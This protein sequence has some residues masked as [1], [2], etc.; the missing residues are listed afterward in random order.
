MET[1]RHDRLTRT[2]HWLS[3]TVI[4]W[5]T[6]SGFAVTLLSPQS[7]LR[8]WIA[9]FNISLATLFTPVFFFRIF[10][11][12]RTSAP[13][14]PG[15]S[16]IRYRLGKFG[17]GVLYVLTIIVLISGFLMMTEGFDVFGLIHVPQP[18]QSPLWNDRF[19][20]IHRYST[21]ALLLTIAVHIAA[22]VHHHRAG[23]RLL[24][25]ML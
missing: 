7:G 9:D 20:G 5:I 18:L 13:P 12:L 2:L 19:H 14:L 1:F 6:L 25:R 23:R 11:A 21:I 22:V 15:I 10:H 8:V 24:A 17:H 3:A 16:A 4:L